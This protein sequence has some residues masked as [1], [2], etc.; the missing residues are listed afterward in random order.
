MTFEVMNASEVLI[1]LSKH[2][3]LPNSNFDLSHLSDQATAMLPCMPFVSHLTG[4][5]GR[6]W[7]LL[8]ETGGICETENV[9]KSGV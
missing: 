5:L 2:K 8:R 6:S 1:L 3:L 9:L 4:Q 7:G